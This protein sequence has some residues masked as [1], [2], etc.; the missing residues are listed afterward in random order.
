MR[1]EGSIALWVK[2]AVI[3]AIDRIGPFPEVE[4]VETI[5][6]WTDERLVR[7]QK[8]PCSDSCRGSMSIP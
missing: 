1:M 5:V 7:R 6:V 2:G 3:T 8:T 4:V